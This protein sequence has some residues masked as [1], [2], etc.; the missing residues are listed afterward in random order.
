M[1]RRRAE[2]TGERRRSRAGTAGAAGLMALA[3]LAA[4]TGAGD[5]DGAGTETG[6]GEGGGNLVTG[7]GLPDVMAELNEVVGGDPTRYGD[8]SIYPEYAVVEAQDPEALDHID[9]YTW[10]DG[11]VGE[12]EPVHLSGPQE[13]VD[14][15]LF[16]ETNVPW[17]ELP[18]WAERA[19]EATATNEP[20]AIED[21]VASY[22]LVRRSFSDDRPI[23]VSVYINGPRR[24]GYVEFDTAGEIIMTNV[25]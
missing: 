21:P 22:I 9:R 5:G 6:S 8:V 25:S 12:P 11:E 14:L 13:E 20:V 7:D 10:R 3:V 23:T 18:G 2:R 15:E 1:G 17:D 24:S 19:E 16:P 4:C